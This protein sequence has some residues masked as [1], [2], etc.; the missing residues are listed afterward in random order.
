MWGLHL[1]L[2]I[3]GA[4]HTELMDIAPFSKFKAP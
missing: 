3:A 2:C 1:A 4:V